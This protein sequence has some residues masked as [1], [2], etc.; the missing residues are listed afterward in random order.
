MFEP[1]RSVSSLVW[2]EST[3]RY[4]LDWRAQAYDRAAV[5]SCKAWSWAHAPQC[6]QEGPDARCA[7]DAPVAGCP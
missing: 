1:C 4:V 5:N 6:W 3:W 2:D 7:P